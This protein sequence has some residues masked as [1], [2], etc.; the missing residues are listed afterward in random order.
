MGQAKMRV[1]VV[2]ELFPRRSNAFLGTF[3][4]NQLK[5]LEDRH[6]FTVI[7]S[8]APSLRDP[9]TPRLE[10]KVFGRIEIYSLQY[11]PLWLWSLTYLRWLSYEKAN[12]ICKRLFAR[13]LGKLATKLHE[14]F[15]FEVVHGH[16]V[17]LGDEVGPL[18]AR[19]G[20]R[21]CFTLHGLHDHHSRTF[22]E[23]VVASAIANLEKV[24]HVIG[25]SRLALDSYVRAGATFHSMSVIPNCTNIREEGPEDRRIHDFAQGRPVLLTVGFFA[26]EKRIKD[27]IQVL[28]RLVDDGQDPVLVLIGKGPLEGELRQLIHRLDLA[29]RVLLMGPV[30]PRAMGRQYV[31]V[32]M[33]VSAS[34]VESFSMVCLEALT[35]GTPV[36]CTTSIGICE[37]FQ[38]GEGLYTFPVGN[39]QSLYDQILHLLTHPASRSELVR[40]AHRGLSRCATPMVSEAIHRIYEPTSK[41]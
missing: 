37:Y 18:G 17:F 20:I 3:V 28:R 30:A 21:S 4:V 39:L 12:A 6:D 5:A 41:P 33:L 11:F 13:K 1:L 36:V 8:H 23:R 32:D 31:Q 35:L 34:E 25:V 40:K 22:G 38:T 29:S 15:P 24:D 10:R 19:L 27:V 2:T 16:E 7:T 9:F 14:A 26:R